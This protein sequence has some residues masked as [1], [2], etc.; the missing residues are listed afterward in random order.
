MR[1]SPRQIRHL[2]RLGIRHAPDRAGRF[3][4]W[5]GRYIPETLMSAVLDLHGQFLACW[6]DPAFMERWVHLLQDYVGRPSALYH[7]ERL[8]QDLGAQI[9]LKRED[10]NHTGAHKINNTLGQGL[11]ARTLGKK[12]VIAETGAGQHG[13]ATAT[14]AALLGLECDVY[15][16]AVDVERQALNVKKMQMLGA[17]VIAVESGTRTLKDATNE[18]LRQWVARVDDTHY[19]IGSAVGPHP[20]PWMVRAFQSVIGFETMEQLSERGVRADIAVACVGGG[21]N[22]S[23]FFHPMIDSGIEIW[24]VEAGGRGTQPGDNGASL[25]YGSRG[26]L[27]GSMSMIIQTGHGQIQPAHSISAGLDYPGVGPELAWWYE[28]GKIKP[29][30]VD[31]DTARQAVYYLNR[32]EGILP[33]LESA[34]A[35]GALR[36][37]R[38]RIAGKHVVVCISGRGDKDIDQL[39]AMESGQAGH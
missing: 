23:G 3:G 32:L 36:T 39:L 22:S 17:R 27:H 35:I 5:G 29:V 34:H 2:Q 10:L 25:S 30:T 31:D 18:A 12:R 1:Y 6:R 37:Q 15:M 8:S 19:I 13:V 7:A 11:L 26:V 28:R 33:A 38:E 16:G 24:A 21:S 14:A 20:Y 4:T 9:Y